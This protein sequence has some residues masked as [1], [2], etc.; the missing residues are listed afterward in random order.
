MNKIASEIL[1]VAKDILGMDADP[2]Q[3]LKEFFRKNSIPD[4]RLYSVRGSNV[5]SVLGWPSM[6]GQGAESAG[7]MEV[8]WGKIEKFADK[9]GFKVIRNKVASSIL[10]MEFPSQ[11]AM[12]KYLKDHPDADRAN[13]KVVKTQKPRTKKDVKVEEKKPE[14]VP[15]PDFDAIKKP[16][17][18]EDIRKKL[19]DTNYEKA[20]EFLKSKGE[21]RVQAILKGAKG[22]ES[23][24]RTTMNQ[25]K[26][27]DTMPKDVLDGMAEELANLPHQI[28]GIEK[29]LSEHKKD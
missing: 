16:E 19:E 21:D 22:R 14:R 15:V 2:K 12:D 29:A 25:W 27:F 4:Y 10:G 1:A 11:D 23:E 6:Q 9:N 28:K 17:V 18:S 3:L 26:P 8:R 5:V 13:H 7:W 24:I 20:K